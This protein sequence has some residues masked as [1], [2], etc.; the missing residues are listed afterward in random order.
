MFKLVK[1]KQW[2]SIH[3]EQV[4]SVFF[5]SICF[6]VSFLSAQSI[7]QNNVIIKGVVVDESGESLVGVSIKVKG[8]SSASTITDNTGHFSI[9]VPNSASLVFSYVGYKNAELVP[10]GKDIKVVMGVNAAVMD[11]VV[12]VAYGAQKKVTV[13]GSVSSVNNKEI[14]KTP[15][16]NVLTALSGRLP[17][18]TTIQTSGEP[19][20]DNVT[21]F[22]RGAATSND[23][24]PLFLVDGVPRDDVNTMDANEIASVTILKD[25]SATAVFGVRGANGVILITTRRGEKGKNHVSL[26][27]EHSIQEFAFTPDRVNSWDYAVLLNEARANEGVAAAF[28]DEEI[29]KFES[30]KTGNPT[31]PYWYPNNNWQDILFKKSSPMTKGS[32]NIAGGSDRL[33][34]FI[35][36]GYVNQEGIFNVEPES[37]LGYDAQSTM[38]RYN[39]RSNLDYTFS[40]WVKASLDL[41]GY[42]K[43]INGTKGDFNVIFSDALSARP[44]SVG[45]LTLEGNLV[46]TAAGFT[47]VK[48]GRVIQDPSDSVNPAYGALNRSGYKLETRSGADAIGNLDFDLGFLTP[49]LSAKGQVSF[50]S[51]GVNYVNASK[52]YIIYHYSKNSSMDSPYF[53]YD[54]QDDS[55][56]QISLS[57]SAISDWFLNLQGQLNYHRTFNSK[58]AVSGL[59][60]FQ[61]DLKEVNE[62]ANYSEKYL[63]FN[64]I[65]LSARATY[66]Y[67]NKYLLEFNAGYNGSEQFSPENRFGFF[68]AASIGWI[69]SNEPFLE[70]NPVITNL[71]I[72]ASDGKVGNDGF[73]SNRFLYLDN[74]VK[75]SSSFYLT[76]MTN[77]AG[78]SKI[79]ESY[80]GNP[81]I[82]WETAVKQNYGIDLTLFKD[83]SFNFDY[84]LEDRSDILISRGSVPYI[85]GLDQSALS[86]VNM[87]HIKNHGFESQLSYNKVFNKDYSF[88]L[89]VNYCYNKN[90]VIYTDETELTSDY[91]C[92]YRKTGYSLGQNFGYVI[93]RSV[94]MDKGRDGS[95]FFFS[96]ESIA[97]SGLTYGIGTPLPGDFIYVDQNNDGVINDRDKVPIG[98][99]S[100]VPGVTYGGTLSFQVKNF[101]FSALIQGVG[102]FSKYYSGAGIFE[103]YGAHNF[104][105]SHLNRWSEERYAAQQA[106]EDVTISYPRLA[107]S[108]S[109]SLTAN[110]YFIMDASYLRLK[111]LEV[112]YTLPER[113]SKLAGAN[114]IRI[115]VN[116]NNLLTKSHLK[117]K[118]YD[119]E[120]TNA[121]TYPTMRTY[122]MGVNVVF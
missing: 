26:S 45:P 43:K 14:L 17:G 92:R 52:S 106:G 41:S 118:N 58:H 16:A 99:S 91:A 59:L 36:A 49:G 62:N 117:T 57:R 120:Q 20:R 71:K 2:R 1:N 40:R 107:N 104:Y 88:R 98:Y 75:S 12:V 109:T 19:G 84:F 103:T 95:G 51:S 46:Q 3:I 80:I 34:Y 83:I 18:L 81:D 54:G 31:D 114:S 79:S 96:K 44:T 9:S 15:S 85:Q 24:S 7:Q 87:G 72:R 121:I 21:M 55:D 110:D 122:N 30:W 102:K 25:A 100:T 90:K 108:E 67:D 70:N 69:I 10:S 39:F 94:D 113:A 13:T 68:P 78:G 53:T 50:K 27:V 101:D 38:N 76:S 66:A 105:S 111:N 61:R 11:E 93:D 32:L 47:D 115:Y 86:L 35:N 64:L 8:A 23:Q 5:M 48:S 56:G 28:S 22:L 89:S 73:G 82:T 42:I 74:I 116:G 6:N 29:A 112:G 37:S 77:L 63:P 119:P 60:L 65:G 33:Q 4:L 97:S